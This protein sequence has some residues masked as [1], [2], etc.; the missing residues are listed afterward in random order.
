MAD[1]QAATR[2]L[3]AVLMGG[4]FPAGVDDTPENRGL[5]NRISVSVDK[6]RSEGI[7]PVMPW[8]YTTMP[9]EAV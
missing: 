5:W 8:D 6:M 1:G 9:D 4:G 2:M 3:H 7:H